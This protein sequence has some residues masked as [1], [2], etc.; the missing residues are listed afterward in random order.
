[1]A[2]TPPGRTN[3]AKLTNRW[4]ARMSNSRM[5]QTVPVLVDARLHGA[6]GLR[7]TTNSPLTGAEH[8]LHLDD[9][10]WVCRTRDR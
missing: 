6:V 1:M 2:R 5:E 9:H 8:G 10:H 4:M 7:H 3:F